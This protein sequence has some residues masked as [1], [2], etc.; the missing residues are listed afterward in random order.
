MMYFG[1]DN[2]YPHYN[3]E[4]GRGVEN[5]DLTKAWKTKFWDTIRSHSTAVGAEQGKS[6]T[7]NG[8]EINGAKQNRTVNY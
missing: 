5:P 6:E 4:H 2:A 3:E 1:S 8:I 7:Y